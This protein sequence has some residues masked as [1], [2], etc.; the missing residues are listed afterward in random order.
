MNLYTITNV[1]TF[2]HLTLAQPT[3]LVF[4]SPVEYWSQSN[5]SSTTIYRSKNQKI[6]SLKANKDGEDSSLVVITK[7]G[8]F[9]FKLKSVRSMEPMIFEVKEA[10]PSHTY[11]LLSKN[12]DFELFDGGQ[13]YLLKVKSQNIS[14]VNDMPA[15]DVMYL[16]KNSKIKINSEFIDL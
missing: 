12:S 1:A 10:K 7:D 13:V 9:S 5:D 4:N 8:P 15:K 3:T 2:L 14:T 6:L 11:F 16:P